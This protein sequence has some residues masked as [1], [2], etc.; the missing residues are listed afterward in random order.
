MSSNSENYFL[1]PEFYGVDPNKASE[2]YKNMNK[3]AE[4]KRATLN[5]DFCFNADYNI[6]T[7]KYSCPKCKNIEAGNSRDIGHHWECM[8]YKTKYCQQNTQPLNLP[9]INPSQKS[10]SSNLPTT[11]LPTTN[12]SLNL[13][14][15]SQSLPPINPLQSLISTNP[16]TK[17][18]NTGMRKK[19]FGA[20]NKKL[21]GTQKRK[22]AKK[23]QKKKTRR[24]RRKSVRRNSH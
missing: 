16:Y 23:N 4:E 11:N 22:R 20:E 5:K 8:Y 15:N 21:G 10:E 19:D 17:R 2:Q 6:E 7:G 1:D 3:A 24:Y 13:P 18:K 12:P 14:Q 9:I